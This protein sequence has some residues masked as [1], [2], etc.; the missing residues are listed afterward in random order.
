VALARAQAPG[1]RDSIGRDYAFFNASVRLVVERK[2]GQQPSG[3]T[4][5]IDPLTLL[6]DSSVLFVLS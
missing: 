2:D 4:F 3:D 6:P 1:T 5:S